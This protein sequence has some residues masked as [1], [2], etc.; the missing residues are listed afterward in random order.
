MEQRKEQLQQ[1][2]PGNN[3]DDMA[4]AGEVRGLQLVDGLHQMA[5]TAWHAG[6]MRH[7]L[8]WVWVEA[9][10][11]QLH[12]ISDRHKCCFKLIASACSS[13]FRWYPMHTHG[14]CRTTQAALVVLGI[15]PCG[16]SPAPIVRFHTVQPLY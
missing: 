16:L 8:G 5:C 14:A 6:W 11:G 2:A 1:A 15:T 9:R 10:A 4:A 7:C 3:L 12:V 13:R